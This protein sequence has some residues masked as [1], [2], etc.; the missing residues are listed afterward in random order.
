MSTERINRLLRLVTILH[1][2]TAGTP[3][4][5]AA[6]VG[7]SRRTVFRDLTMLKEAGIPH[8]FAQGQGYRIGRSAFLPAINLTVVETLGLL[9]LGKTAAA[10]RR[11]PMMTPALSAINKLTLTIPEQLRHACADLVSRITIDPGGQVQSDRE[12]EHYTT[13]QTCIDEGRCCRMRYGSPSDPQPC[14]IVLNPYALHFAARAW[15]VLG[16][17]SA[18]REVRIFKLTRIDSL[19]MLE[20]RFKKP[21]RFSIEKKIGKAWT[22]IPEGKVH[23]VEL[24]FTPRVAKNVIEVRWHSTQQATMRDDGSLLL[25]FEVDGLREISWWVCG[26]A[27]QVKVRKPKELADLVGH[28]LRRAAERY[29]EVK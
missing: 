23:Q 24:E 22:M 4:D 10:Q 7:V 8:Y 17:S 28:M 14:E 9:V 13:L 29:D 20:R 26:Y 2:G 21:Q 11:R 15:Y 25:S 12:S 3:D 19:Q 1:A 27:D 6:Q 18:H 5:L 16:R